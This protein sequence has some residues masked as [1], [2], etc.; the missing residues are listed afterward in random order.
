MVEHKHTFVLLVMYIFLPPFSV[1]KTILTDRCRPSWVLYALAGCVDTN[2]V[3]SQTI[4]HT[5][6]MGVSLVSVIQKREYNLIHVDSI[7][8]YKTLASRYCTRHVQTFT[9]LCSHRMWATKASLELKTLLHSPHVYPEPGGLLRS[10]ES[11]VFLSGG[12]ECFFCPLTWS[13][14]ASF[15][16]FTRL[17]LLLLFEC[18]GL[19]LRGRLTPRFGGPS[20]VFRVPWMAW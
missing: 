9:L 12:G 11:F 3:G 15:L 16:L 17:P 8:I 14:S 2:Y 10:P 20:M 19:V 18:V 13:F 5:V 1:L 4:C 6:D 7:S